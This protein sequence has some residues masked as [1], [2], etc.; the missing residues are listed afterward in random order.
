MH[1]LA[2]QMTDWADHEPAVQALILIGSQVRATQDTVW[3]ADAQSDWDF[4]IIT[5]DP[6]RFARP[7]W[8]RG[9]ELPLRTYA[10]RRAAISGLPKV[11]ALFAGAEADFVVLPADRMRQAR[12]AVAL[13]LHRRITGLRRSLQDL[14][15]IVRPGWQLLKGAAR[16]QSFLEKVVAEVPDPR[17]SDAEVRNLAEGFV[18]DAVWVRRKIDR[19]EWLAAQRTLH[20][21]LAETNFRLLHELK[22]RRGER[23]FPEARRAERIL[24]E[25][26]LALVSIAALPAAAAL[27]PA[28]EQAEATCRAL[29]RALIGDS[30]RW[31]DD[32]GA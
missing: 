12:W 31:P 1:T 19:G 26:E 17:L 22:L 13:G 27:T 20:R 30:W 28:L 7:D 15:V 16:W 9:L 29:V 3:R 6:E 21:A 11:A 25:S 24:S 2:E 8:A 14:A 18:C 10:V 4:Q 23:S 32:V 5:S